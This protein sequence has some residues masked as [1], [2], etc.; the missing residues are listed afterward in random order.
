[1]A[2]PM[3][4]YS[5]MHTRACVLHSYTHM[6]SRE[7]YLPKMPPTPAADGLMTTVAFG[8][9]PRSLRPCLF[10]MISMDPKVKDAMEP[11]LASVVLLLG[12][13]KAFT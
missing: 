4:E 3:L 5:C 8:W 12:A 11:M 7:R 9:V 2:V 6:A 13:L 1:M 10:G